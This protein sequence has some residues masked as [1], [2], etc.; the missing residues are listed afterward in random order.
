MVCTVSIGRILIDTLI[1]AV[2]EKL[3]PELA[4]FRKDRGTTEQIYILRKIIEQ[5]VEWQAS[6]YVNFVNFQKCFDSLARE[7]IWQRIR[8]YGIPEKL[9]CIIRNWYDNSESSV[10]YE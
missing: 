2:D 1:T 7:R 9:V 6:Q 3:R 10:I 8:S 4:G 5:G